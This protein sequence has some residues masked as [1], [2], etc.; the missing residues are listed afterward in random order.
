MGAEQ[1]V[2][3]LWWLLRLLA[4]KRSG[5]TAKQI[6]DRIGQSKSTVVRDIDKLTKAA[7]RSSKSP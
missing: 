2:V 3:R 7:L 6:S 5:L 1:Q 4:E